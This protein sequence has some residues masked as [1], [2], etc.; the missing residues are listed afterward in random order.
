MGQDL[1]CKEVLKLPKYN[2]YDKRL[3]LEYGASLWVRRDKRGVFC[4]NDLKRPWKEMRKGKEAV[5]VCAVMRAFECRN[6][7]FERGYG[8]PWTEV[9]LGEVIE[10][11]DWW[12]G[13]V[14]MPVNPPAWWMKHS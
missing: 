11:P 12:H 7:R 13:E 14:G 6:V 4:R 3:G 8:C 2:D 10:G 9:Q 5:K 1:G